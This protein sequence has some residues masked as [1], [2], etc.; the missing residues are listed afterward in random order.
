MV[1]L[2]IKNVLEMSDSELEEYRKLLNVS[3]Y[4]NP[5]LDNK[6]III[7]EHK[8]QRGRVYVTFLCNL[9]RRKTIQRKSN[10]DNKSKHFCSSQ[11]ANTIKRSR[12]TNRPT[13]TG[14]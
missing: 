8:G 3:V 7:G 5:R 9:C 4:V 1:N 10:F 13:L 12:S 6:T 11:C 2:H 14:N